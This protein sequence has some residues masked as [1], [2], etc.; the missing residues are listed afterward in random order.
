MSVFVSVT[1]VKRKVIWVSAM[2]LEPGH[3][4]CLPCYKPHGLGMHAGE[5]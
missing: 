5:F 4:Q 1:V 2:A 3:V